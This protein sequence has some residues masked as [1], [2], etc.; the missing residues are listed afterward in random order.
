MNLVYT[1]PVDSVRF[2]RALIGYSNSGYYMLFASRLIF[3]HFT[4]KGTNWRW[5]S[6]GLLYTKTIIHLS[7]GEEW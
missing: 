4:K 7:V 2:S 5:L 1:K 3:P 6:T